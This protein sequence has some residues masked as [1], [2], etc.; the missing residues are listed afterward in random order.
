MY[1]VHTMRRM[2]P[3]MHSLLRTLEQQRPWRLSGKCGRVYASQ[4][5]NHCLS[6]EV[7]RSA[8]TNTTA[9]KHA[10]VVTVAIGSARFDDDVNTGVA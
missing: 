6:S 10:V 9:L 8:Q 2:H 1:G 5:N 7:P 4:H 3:C